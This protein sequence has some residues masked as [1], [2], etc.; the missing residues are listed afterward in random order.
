[1]RHRYGALLPAGPDWVVPPV[2]WWTLAAAAVL[3]APTIAG[4]FE[5]YTGT[6]WQNGHGL[7]LPFAIVAL[8]RARLRRVDAAPGRGCRGTDAA[9]SGRARLRGIDAAPA[10]AGPREAAPA[11]ATPANPAPAEAA[12][13]KVAP[14]D[15]TSAESSPWGWP[16]ALG[17]VALAVLDS[18]AN[19]LHLATVGLALF[20]TGFSLLALGARRTRALAV[21]LGLCL[22]L[23]PLPTSL[24]EPLGLRAGSAMGTAWVLKSLG[25]PVFRDGYALTLPN[26]SFT[27]SANCSGFSAFYAGLALALLL[28]ACTASRW[29]RL[30]LLLAPWPLALAAN[31][32]RAAALI[33]A[34]PVVGRDLVDTAVH[35]LSGIG[36]FWMVMGGL[37]L[38]ADRR[39]V[40][41]TLQ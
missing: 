38:F 34:E 31:S 4:L 21:P 35:G 24:G 18:G 15:A 11:K 41:E 30:L 33:G 13:L 22:F 8:G 20:L 37:V 17:G 19:T 14:A 29:R 12:P 39:A 2:A 5:A 3:F 1:M 32:V 26:G 7:L 9:L 16:L 40:R 27:F 6:I 10:E 36:A 23:L 25:V 28:G